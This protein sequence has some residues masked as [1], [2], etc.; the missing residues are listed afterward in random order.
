M[1]L[2]HVGLFADGAAVRTV[3]T[4]TYRVASELCDGMITV[5]TD[6]LCA[7]I[8]HGFNDTRTVLEP[9]G[10]LAIAGATKWAQKGLGSLAWRSPK[11]VWPADFETGTD[12]G[13]TRRQSLVAVA[14]GANVDFNRCVPGWMLRPASLALASPLTPHPSSPLPLPGCGS[15]PSTP[16][17][18]RPCWPCACRSGGAPC[19]TSTTSW[20][21]AT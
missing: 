18:R 4:E 6:E 1:T 14:S 21:S 16:T 12:V 11:A 19:R 15:S 9:A 20:A 2:D 7:A 8:K 3:G 10:A 5:T 13:Q 17:S